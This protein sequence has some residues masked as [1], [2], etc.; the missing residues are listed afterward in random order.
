MHLHATD[1]FDLEAVPCSILVQLSV[2]DNGSKQ[3]QTDLIAGSLQDIAVVL[4]VSNS[5]LIG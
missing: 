2:T 1:K 4:T 3:F 5:L